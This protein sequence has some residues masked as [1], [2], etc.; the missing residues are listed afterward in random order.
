RRLRHDLEAFHGK[1]DAKAVAAAWPHLSSEDRHV[2]YAAR[3]AV[4]SQPLAEWQGQA[5]AEQQPTAA[6]TA[7]L[8]LARC[9]PPDTQA[10]V[11]AGAAAG[12]LRVLHERPQAVAAP[13]G[14]AAVVRRRR[15]PLW[16]RGQLQELP[17]ELLPGSGRQPVRGR[18]EG[19]G[20]AAA[21]D[22]PGRRDELRD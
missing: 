9:G 12:V 4:E 2:R 17:A 7:L 13:A 20:A 21:V 5:L 10:A 1:K 19:A 8:A 15:P 11:G 14:A 22:R 6:P 3:V 18:A 16:G